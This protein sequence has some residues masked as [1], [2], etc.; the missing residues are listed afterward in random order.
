MVLALTAGVA[1][2]DLTALHHI[3]DVGQSLLMHRRAL[4]F[5]ERKKRGCVEI[6]GNGTEQKLH[7]RGAGTLPWAE[8]VR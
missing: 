6:R 2:T 4:F 1:N 8:H 7:G 5:S 3:R